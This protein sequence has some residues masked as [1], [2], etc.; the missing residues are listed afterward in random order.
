MPSIKVTF[1]ISRVSADAAKAP[2]SAAAAM[3][4]LRIRA[5]VSAFIF[6]YSFLVWLPEYDAVA[7][8][9]FHVEYRV[10]ILERAVRHRDDIGRFARLN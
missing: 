2:A 4:T 6:K 8:D 5:R 1:S 9:E 10:Y 7:H 3:M